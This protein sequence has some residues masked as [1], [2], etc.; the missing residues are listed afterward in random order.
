MTAVSEGEDEYTSND[1]LIESN[2]HHMKSNGHKHTDDPISGDQPLLNFLNQHG[3]SDI[4]DEMLSSKLTLSHFHEV[5]MAD[6]DALCIDL[7]LSSSQKIRVKHAVKSLQRKAQNESTN[8]DGN[9]I[10]VK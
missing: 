8:D 10:E 2:K 9:G 4:K 3:L 1:K 5:D 7:N 6:L